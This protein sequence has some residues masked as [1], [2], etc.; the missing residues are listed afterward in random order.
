M[1]LS[2]TDVKAVLDQSSW[3]ILIMVSTDKASLVSLT[4]YKC[5]VLLHS[6]NKRASISESAANH[7]DRHL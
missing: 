7:E 6:A 3:P 4:S 5:R 1:P 2:T